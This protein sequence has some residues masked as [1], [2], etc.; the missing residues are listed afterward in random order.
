VNSATARTLT[1]VVAVLLVVGAVA[2]KLAGGGGGSGSTTSNG[3]PT[4]VPAGALRV[5]FAISPGPDTLLAKPIAEFNARHVQVDGKTVVVVPRTVSSGEA[6]DE[7]RGGALKPTVWSPASSLW[8]RLFTEEAD[9]TYLAE[10]PVSLARTPLVIAMWEPEARALG[11]P[12]RPLGWADVLREA[13]QPTAF[14]RF[15]HP[16]WGSFRLGH[17]NPDFSTSGLSAVAAEYYAATGKS[18]GL[19]LADVDRPAVR[20]QIRDIESAIVHYGDTTLFFEQQLA[21]HGPAF[22]TAVAMEEDTLVDFNQRLRRKGEPRLVAIYPREGTFYSDNPLYVLNA[23]W[24]TAA[25]RQAAQR[26]VSYL[27]T[28][29]VQHVLEQA[30]FRPSNPS[31]SPG[32]S[33][34]AANGV[35]PSQPARALS[36]PDPAVMGRVRALWHQDRKPADV[37]VVLDTSGSMAD[38]NKLDEAKQGLLAFLRPLN[39]RD[40]VALITFA[41]QS[42]LLQPLLPLTPHNRGRL[43]N[44]IVGLFA[45]G[46][47]AIYDTTRTALQLLRQQGDPK[48][49]EAVVLLTDG[50]DNKSSTPL[51]TLVDQL[52]RESEESHPRIFT[53]AYGADAS[54]SVL[55]RI[56]DASGG[57]EYDGDP[58][59][60]RK[61]YISISSFF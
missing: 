46:G 29:A 10:R 53:I 23:P 54:S 17:T 18:E 8:G 4:S 58:S 20:A 61:V 57:Q 25:Q 47:T 43:G 52:S 5:D 44:R 39:T 32:A 42:R 24:T 56:A 26:F 33:I 6:L 50:Q 22:A 49:I 15:G 35:D 2:S 41:S 40:R 13:R 55:Q 51:G 34:S 9:K 48:H 27:Q 37:V 30:G 60:I 21:A 7:L 45:N 28:D 19:T 16:E 12:R 14:A 59:Q 31:A 11:W 3:A 1:I 38:E 36:L